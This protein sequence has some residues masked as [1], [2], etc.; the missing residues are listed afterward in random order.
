M[1]VSVADLR[2]YLAQNSPPPPIQIHLPMDGLA[3]AFKQM[4]GTPDG[5]SLRVSERIAPSV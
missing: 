3:L 1:A 5:S 2:Q 4:F